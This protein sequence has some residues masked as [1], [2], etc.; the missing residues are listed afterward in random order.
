MGGGGL[1]HW[2]ST[3]DHVL[4]I[5]LLT[6]YLHLIAKFRFNSELC[7]LQN[8]SNNDAIINN[9]S[10]GNKQELIKELRVITDFVEWCEENHNL[11]NTSKTKDVVIDFRRTSTTQTQV[12]IQG[13]DI[14]DSGLF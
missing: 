1:Q 6:L 7:H 9:M 8:L 5:P 13:S 10:E 3:R 11:I 2:G 12:N 4:M 14:I